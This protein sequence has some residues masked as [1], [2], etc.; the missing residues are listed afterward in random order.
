MSDVQCIAPVGDR[1]GEA[2]TWE[3]ETRSLWWTDV[4]R[5][6]IHRYQE[7]TGAVSSWFFDE[8]VVA[9]ALTGTPG[10]LLVALAS[11]LILW[12][13][14][15]DRRRDH[16]H[17][18]E[19]W[20]QVRLNDGRC[21]PRGDFW[22]GSMRN[23]VGPNGE[24]GEAGGKDGV[25]VRVRRDGG[26]DVLKTGIGISNTLCWS[27]DRTRFMFADTLADTIWAYDYDART[28][29]ISNERVL[30]AGWGRGL[31]DGSAIDDSGVLWNCRFGGGCIVR[32]APDGTVLGTL[33]MPVRNITTCAFGGADLSTLYI[34][35]AAMMTDAS[36]RLA[37]SL[38]ATR[39]GV[40]GPD[41]Y[42]LAG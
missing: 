13:P 27:P 38:F 14:A 21:D 3:A 30:L 16:G 8:P 28:G 22:V 32:I 18:L 33:E 6:L 23:N 1:C 20:P 10:T 36:D 2:A 26:A 19:G 37:G 39:P 4:N 40:S 7:T 17:A 25:L 11:R 15:T 24:P 34:T 9:L 5:F 29:D 12:E 42:R 31:P 41:A 35:T